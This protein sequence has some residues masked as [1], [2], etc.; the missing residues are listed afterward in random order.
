MPIFLL[1]MFLFCEMSPVRAEVTD[2]VKYRQTDEGLGKYIYSC[3]FTLDHGKKVAICIQRSKTY[4]AVGSPTS[5]WEEVFNEDLRKVLY[6][7]YGGPEDKGYKVVETSCA[8]AAANGDNETTIGAAVLEEI[9]LLDSPPPNFRIWKVSTN[10]GFSQDLAFFTTLTTGELKLEKKSTDENCTYSLEEAIY[11][12]FSDEECTLQVGELI[13]DED[14]TSQ[15]ITLDEGTYYVKELQAPE[16]YLLSE[17]IQEVHILVERTVTLVAS[18]EPIPPIADLVIRKVN[19]MGEGLSGAEFAVYED[20]NCDQLVSE[21]V[22]EEDGK[23]VFS[24][25]VKDKT[26]YLK[27]L[28]AP[29]GYMLSEEVYPV[30]ADGTEV[31]IINEKIFVLPNTGSSGELMVNFLGIWNVIK[32]LKRRNNMKKNFVK[33]GCTVL[34]VCML[35]ASQMSMAFAAETTGGVVD[36]KTGDAHITI[37]GNDEQSLKGKTWKLHKL[38]DAENAEGGESIRYTLNSTYAN[39]LKKVVAGRINKNAN[40]VTEYD[41]L[42]YIQKINENKV[43]G[44]AAEQKLENRYST[45]RYFVEELIAQIQKDQIQGETIEIKDATASN[46]VEIKGLDYGYYIIEDATEVSE[47]HSAASL[48]IVTTANPTAILNIKSDYPT[49]TKKVYEEDDNVGWNDVADYEIGETVPFKYTSNIPNINGY[50]KYYYA[51]HDSMDEALTLQND[52]IQIQISGSLNGSDK[53][54]TLTKTEYVLNTNPGNN[55]TFQIQISDIKAIVDRE[56]PQFS[57]NENQYGQTVTVSYNALLN[58]KAAEDTGRP[59]YENDVRLEF[60]NNPN[61]VEG[62]QSADTGFTPWDTVVCFSYRLDGL[63]VNNKLTSL[64]NAKFKIYRDA[65]CTEAVFD[66]EYISDENGNFTIY[67]LDS[68]TYYLKE[69]EA[70]AGYR[71]IDEPIMIQIEAAFKSDRN[72]YEKGKGAGDEVLTLSGNAVVTTFYDGE[73]HVETVEMAA[74]QETGSLALTVVNQIGSK[75][76]VTGSYMMPVLLAIGGVC[77]YLGVKPG[78]EKNE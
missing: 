18:D 34:I 33:F 39:S 15:T 4:P 38:F 46:S 42:D 37:Q 44:S 51:W 60:S 73:E 64:A 55:E 31:P 48:A 57:N 5:E 20:E 66:E 59:G 45:Y 16:G 74:E 19:V 76:P 1:A 41:I 61:L 22:T 24:G 17:E 43:E 69:T 6:Y 7:G 29:E 30:E 53:T 58:D 12:V 52:S 49:V 3:L 36:F 11:G 63:K 26:Y 27:E 35:A 13:T 25:L 68:G 9:R 14:G 71:P 54:Y 8:A 32:S 21:G 62:K 23:V 70:P 40:E 75:L 77:I 65:E 47:T 72:T 56:F 50:S 78:K 10:G 2:S 28:Q 67:G